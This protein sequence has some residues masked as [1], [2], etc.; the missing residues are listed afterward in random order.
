VR[1]GSVYDGAPF[2]TV[3]AMTTLRTPHILR[4]SSNVRKLRENISHI[5]DEGALGRID[6]EIQRNVK[7]IFALGEN[8]YQFG[9]Q[10]SAN[11]RQAVSRSYYGAYNVSRA[12]R[13]FVS[14]AFSTDVKEHQKFHDLPDDFPKRSTYANQ[15]KILRE[16]R[17]LCDYDHTAEEG[18][19]IIGLAESL[20]LVAEFIVDARSYLR[21][22][23]MNV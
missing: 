8:H 10:H 3:V 15:L 9:Q 1:I 16:D 12:I 5:L 2:W 17:N 23:G 22:R 21:G 14:G 18:D 6:S 20:G 7:Q 13:L 19:L 4:A 11:W